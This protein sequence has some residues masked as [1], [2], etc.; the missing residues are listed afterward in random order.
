MAVW[1]ASQYLRFEEE[2]TRASVDLLARVPL[3]DPSE[4]VDLGCGPGNSTELVARR[5]PQARLTGLDNSADML[6]KARE[7]LPDVR[8]KEAD[9]N[10]WRPA[11][12]VDLLF[13]NAV[14]QWLP[15]SARLL[16]VSPL[17]IMCR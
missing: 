10:H 4:A 1:S 14:L 16:N 7:R 11:A 6:A 2:R 15:E 8:F 9:L 3:E 13:A 17:P 5:F 12:P